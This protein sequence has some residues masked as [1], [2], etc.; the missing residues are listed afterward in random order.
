MTVSINTASWFGIG[1]GTDMITAK[2]MWV[3]EI[4]PAKYISHCIS[5]VSSIRLIALVKI[6]QDPLSIQTSVVLRTFTC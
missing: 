3:F 6:I 1:L 4:D 2:D 5:G